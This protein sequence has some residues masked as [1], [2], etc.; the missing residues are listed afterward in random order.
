MYKE[1]RKKPNT[2]ADKQLIYGIR[3]VEEAIESNQEFERIY[4]AKESGSALKGLSDTIRA[5][6]LPVHVVPTPKLNRLCRGNH[7]GVVAFLSIIPNVAIGEI[8]TRCFEEGRDPKILMLDRITDVRNFGALSRSALAFGF[9]A[10]VV[11]HKGSAL[12]HEDAVKASAGALLKMPLAK[13]ASLAKCVDEI[14]NY[15][16][17]IICISE[18]ATESISG[19]TLNKPFCVILGNEETGIDSYIL[20]QADASYKINISESIDSLNVSVAGAIAMFQLAQG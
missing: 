5:N 17:E 14:K 16:L 2:H 15:G 6:K 7:Q 3:A 11:P 4:L 19:K 10:I 18:K 8:I 20:G 1:N 12:I 9:N 13:V